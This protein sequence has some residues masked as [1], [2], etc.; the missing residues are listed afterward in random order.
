LLR[1]G[2]GALL[3]GGCGE[4]LREGCG[5]LLRGGCGES[6][7]G[8]ASLRG[9]GRPIVLAAEVGEGRQHCQDAPASLIC[10]SD[11]V[12]HNYT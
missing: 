7:R 8:G 1:G 3:R 5:A 9:G 4:L 11:S 12:R 2:C 10:V 6:L